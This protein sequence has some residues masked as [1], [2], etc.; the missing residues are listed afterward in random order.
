M[1][2]HALSAFPMGAE[3]A[4]FISPAALRFRDDKRAARAA[5]PGISLGK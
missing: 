1:G 2:F 5:L 3:I 4:P